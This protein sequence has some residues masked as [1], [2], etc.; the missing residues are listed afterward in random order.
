MTSVTISANRLTSSGKLDSLAA[1]DGSKLP[2]LLGRMDVSMISDGVDLLDS[3]AEINGWEFDHSNAT[4]K[5]Y[6]DTGTPF[7][8]C[9]YN[10]C[11]GGGTSWPSIKYYFDDDTSPQEVFVQFY[12]RRDGSIASGSKFV[13]IYGK[14]TGSDYSNATFSNVYDSASIGSILYGDG[15][16]LTN[17]ADNGLSYSDGYE[18][19]SGRYPTVQTPLTRTFVHIGEWTGSDWGAGT[20]WHKFQ[21]RIK[22]NSGTSA[23]NE[24]NDGVFEVRINDVIR[25]AGYNIMNKNPI[26]QL[27]H[28]I[29]FS[30][31]MQNNLGFD[32]DFKNITVSINGWV[33]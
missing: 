20:Q 27:Y 30:S 8:R 13:K 4:T 22:Q 9:G 11:V 24:I 33:D 5:K 2:I 29:E 14:S 19:Q 18:A 10:N 26:N 12:A 15:T 17:D 23:A 3:A 6:T 7:V 28:Y 25:C 21:I 32:I 1:P 16:G 31:L